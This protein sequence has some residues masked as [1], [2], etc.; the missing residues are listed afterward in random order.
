MI[1]NKRL[2]IKDILRKYEWIDYEIE[3]EDELEEE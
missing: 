1:D 3:T 2:S